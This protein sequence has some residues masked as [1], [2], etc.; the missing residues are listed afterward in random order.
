MS[1]PVFIFRFTIAQVNE[2]L[3]LMNQGPYGQV[4]AVINEFQRQVK[5]QAP[6]VAPEPPLPPK[7]NGDAQAAGAASQ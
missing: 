5:D 3:T 4:Q 7:A 1:E 2:M 6:P